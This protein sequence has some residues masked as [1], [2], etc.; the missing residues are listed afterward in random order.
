MDHPLLKFEQV[1]QLSPASWAYLGDAVYELYIRN[2]YL[3]PPKRSQLYHQLVVSQVRAESQARHLRSLEPYL[4]AAELEV[5]RRGRNA[6]IRCPKRI[7]PQT[8]Q[9][10][11]S[12]E[13]L[14]GYL[15]LTDPERL[16][17]LLAKLDLESKYPPA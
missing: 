16:S 10:A 14:V 2:F 6:T 13:T 4:S 1:Q 3:R 9:L 8:Y 12:L 17:Q 15:Y 11:T 7:N 5:V